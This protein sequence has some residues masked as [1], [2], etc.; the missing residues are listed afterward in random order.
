V[1]HTAAYRLM[2]TVRDAIPQPQPLATAEFTTSRLRP[3]TIAGHITET[4][5]RIRIAFAAA[6][7]KAEPSRSVARSL[8]LSKP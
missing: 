1:L 4:A 8:Q 3:L 7:P 2:L 6:C 5:T